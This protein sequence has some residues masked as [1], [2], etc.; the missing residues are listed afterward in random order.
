MRSL[1]APFASELRWWGS[2]ALVWSHANSEAAKMPVYQG[3]G[4][5]RSP[6]RKSVISQFLFTHFIQ[7]D[8]Q[9]IV[10]RVTYTTTYPK[11]H[12]RPCTCQSCACRFGHD[13]PISYLP[14]VIVCVVSISE[15]FT[16][17]EST[18]VGCPHNVTV[19]GCARNKTEQASRES[20]VETSVSQKQKHYYVSCNA[21][22]AYLDKRLRPCASCPAVYNRTFCT[23]HSSRLRCCP[24]R[25][26]RE[27][28]RS[29]HP[30]HLSFLLVGVL[31]CNWDTPLP[32]C[33]VRWC[34]DWVP[35]HPRSCY[36][37]M[38]QRGSDSCKLKQR[39]LHVATLLTN[40]M[41]FW[42]FEILP[43]LEWQ[44]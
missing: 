8:R 20:W 25:R 24:E 32:R 38:H 5:I 17:L 7:R 35:V 28:C 39:S 6:C 4:K 10:G 26:C 19:A 12:N 43:P 21:A 37:R 3:T 42:K 23:F 44:D 41:A 9:H 22:S 31:P 14:W 16:K 13:G 30:T 1:S 2:V 40:G 15:A 27:K 29:V 36:T 18:S 11:R 33:S 34:W